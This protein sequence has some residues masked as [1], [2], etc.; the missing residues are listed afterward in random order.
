MKDAQLA[1]NQ[2]VIRTPGT[3]MQ[4]NQTIVRR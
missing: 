4:H 3:R 2:T 1:L